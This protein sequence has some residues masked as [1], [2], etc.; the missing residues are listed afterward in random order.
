MRWA[1]LECA[2]R[3]I[4]IHTVQEREPHPLESVIFT[5][6]YRDRAGTRDCQ[7]LSRV[8]SLQYPPQP[9]GSIP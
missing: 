9:V 3:R 2:V 8:W 4:D 5:C 7:R 1:I 6:S